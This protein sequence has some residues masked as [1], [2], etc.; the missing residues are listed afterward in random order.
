ML[1]TKRHEHKITSHM[2]RRTKDNLIDWPAIYR[3]WVTG[4]FTNGALARKYGVSRAR[5]GQKAKQDGWSTTSGPT[6][7]PV[8]T[9]D[10][11]LDTPTTP[12]VKPGKIKSAKIPDLLKQSKDIVQRLIDEVDTVTT[13]H[14]EIRDM[15]L[16]DETDI[17]RRRIAL[18]AISVGERTKTMKELV[19]TLRMI[20]APPGAK[21]VGR[22][23]K[24]A[25][26]DADQPQGKKAQ[27]QAEAEKSAQTGPFAV[28]SPPKLVVNR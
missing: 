18:K 15:I 23:K 20:E 16:A 12:T 13:Y 11:D 8:V 27:R 2:A 1:L 9:Y 28:P 3:D 21:A 26:D 24:D 25:T 14:G 4:E 10:D 17:V 5:L 6:A 19:T 22:P 7:N